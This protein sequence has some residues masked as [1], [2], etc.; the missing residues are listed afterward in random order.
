MTEIL[1]QIFTKWKGEP[2]YD[3]ENRERKVYE[4]MKQLEDHYLG[5]LNGRPKAD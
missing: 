2:Y 3:R 4:A 1:E 5:L